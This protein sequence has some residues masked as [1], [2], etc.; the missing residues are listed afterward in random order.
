MTATDVEA[1]P[2]RR[3]APWIA[4]AVGVVLAVFVAVLATREP[5]TT[6]VA[7]SP[8]LGR[9]APAITGESVLDG[10]AFDLDDEEG[11]FV[12][13][14]FFATWCT[15]CVN[16]HDD[17]L[18]FATRH[19]A[20]DDA[21]V[22]TVVF[23]QEEADEVRAFFEERGGNWPVIDAGSTAIVD[24]GV[25]GVPESYLVGPEGV[26]RAKI[27]GG[28]DAQKLEDLFRRAASGVEVAE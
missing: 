20:A 9:Q 23:E 13:V 18:A 27:L 24:Y 21:R 22:V 14:N 3:T 19:Q 25:T 5:A 28:I 11:R 16:E 17:L 15:P 12:L 4:A 2:R 26:V 7:D 10:R 8:L 1:R 6:R